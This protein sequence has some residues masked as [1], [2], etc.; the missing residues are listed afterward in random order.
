MAPMPLPP[1]RGS[2]KVVPYQHE[3]KDVFIVLDHQEQLFEHQV[4]LPPLAFVVATML[5]GRRES[6]DVQKEIKEQMKIDV[7][8]DE[9]DS[10]VRDL[11]HHLLLESG[12]TRERRQQMS[13]E[14]TKLP[15]RPAKFVEGT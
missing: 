14:F 4:V 1:F 11:E 15:A 12:R 8:T 2:L 3:G 7:T 6:A 10:V 13:D 9:I 5:D